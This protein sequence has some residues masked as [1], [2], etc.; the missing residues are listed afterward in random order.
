MDIGTVSQMMTV[1]QSHRLVGTLPISIPILIII[2]IALP[3]KKT[4]TFD[5]QLQLAISSTRLVKAGDFNGR[6]Q[7]P[8]AAKEWCMMNHP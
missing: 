3:G 6:P 7:N 4:A 8:R 1:G 5:A 2:L